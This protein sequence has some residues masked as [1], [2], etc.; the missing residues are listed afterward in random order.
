MRKLPVEETLAPLRAALR[1]GNRAVLVAPPGAGKTTR[2]PLALLDEPWLGSGRIVLL[3]PRRLAARAAANRMS[4]TL[5]Q[6]LGE[7]VGL[8]ARMMTAVSPATRVEVVTE[9]V[10]TRMILDDPELAGVGAVILDEFHERSLDADFGLALALD[11]QDGLRPDLRLLVMSATLDGARVADLLSASEAPCPV[12]SSKGR[13]HPIETFYIPRRPD[14]T[15]EQAV[16]SAVAR[17]LAET[18]GDILVF[19]PGQRE[20]RRA[21]DALGERLAGQPIDIRPLHGTLDRADQ[22]AA[23]SPAPAGR[24]KVVLS[25]AIAETSLTIEGVTAVVDAGL[26][27]VPR[28]DVG[29]RL[30]RLETVRVSRA[31]ADQRRGRAGRLG[32]GTCY[33]LWAEPETHSLPAYARPEILSTDLS[34]LV[35]DCAAW[36]VTEPD[37]LAWMDPPPS[38][39]VRAARE[40]LLDLGA[41]DTAGRVTDLGR[42][43]RALPLAP[44][45]AAMIIRAAAL[46]AAGTAA[47]LAALI[48]EPGLGGRSTDIEIRLARFATDRSA[49]AE[50]MRR[51]AARWAEHAGALASAGDGR[52]GD[53]PGLGALLL[54]A[55]PDRLAASRGRGRF[56]LASGSQAVM[57]E[58]EAL[59]GADF[60]VVADL[61]GAGRSARITT[62][63]GITPD[64]VEQLFAA[65]IETRDDV[66]FDS[67]RLA[68]RARRRRILGAITLSETTAA[69]PDPDRAAAVLAEGIASAGLGVLPWTKAQRQLRDRVMFL[70]RADPATWPDLSDEAL[71]A[72]VADWLGPFLAGKAA[73][74]DIT[75][76][77][78]AQALDLLIGWDNR[79]RLDALAPTHWQAPTGHNHPIAYD[80]EHAPSVSLRVQ[81]LFGLGLHPAIDDGRL[82]LTLI[83]LS[84]AHRPIQVTRDLPGFW[85]GSWADVRADLRGR[86]PKHPWPED[87]AN[88][89]PTRHAKRKGG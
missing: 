34:R 88:A 33:R 13:A 50:G 49:R 44:H 23:L 62:A 28:F 56:L 74:R 10:F 47:R 2:V 27:R 87:P 29:A 41:V 26:A 85:S 68:V 55:Y 12:I 3:E 60:L 81:E 57:P 38:A 32:P 18:G 73:V 54:L 20:I 43:L 30:T 77:D 69:S 24:R 52:R 58:D 45:L 17:A 72:T 40:D 15:L 64:E 19:L 11:A 35:L 66:T 5:G 84:P 9:G 25:S 71:G 83:L 89:D 14:A 79:R 67:Q 7:T 6:R 42:R 78:L 76:D 48:T 36:G 61:Q 82:P 31:A 37:S 51:L 22:Y 46:G 80:G 8:R 75:A 63:A 65:G 86:Y 70:R 21:G 1:D 59:A 16:A 53:E 39:A 4:E